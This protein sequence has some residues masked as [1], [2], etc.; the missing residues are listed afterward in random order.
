MKKIALLF[1]SLM[2]ISGCYGA[3][4]T[5]EEALQRV[6][7]SGE[8]PR[9]VKGA[10]NSMKLVMAGSG[11]TGDP[12]YYIFSS[13]GNTLFV[14]A[15]DIAVPL[16]GYTDS[17]NFDTN[18]MPP[19]LKW[20]LGEY[21]REIEWARE[22]AQ[23]KLSFEGERERKSGQRNKYGEAIAPL[24]S[25]TWSQT[26]P[27]N[28]YC[29][30]IN[31]AKTVTGC[32]ATAMAQTMKYHEWPQD[33]I[34]S[35]SYSWNGRRLTSRPLTPDWENM[36]DDYY[37][38]YTDEEAD[39]VARL[40]QVCGYSVEMMY[41][42]ASA[43]GSGAYSQN[44][45]NAMVERFGY[46]KSAIYLLRQFYHQ[47]EWAQMI[48][49]NLKEI[50]PVIY[51]GQGSLGGHS[52][53]CDGYDGNGMFHFNWGWSGMSDGY[54]ILSALDPDALGT[55]GGAGGFN[56]NQDIIL[57]IRRPQEDSVA[58]LPFIA[59]D[60]NMYMEVED[61]AVY[62]VPTDETYGGFF[63]YGNTTGEFAFGLQLK[64]VDTDLTYNIYY[65]EDGVEDNYIELPQYR[66]ITYYGV[67]LPEEIE[68]GR[69]KATPIYKLKENENAE[70]IRF[71]Y[72]FDGYTILVIDDESI[73][74][75]SPGEVLVESFNCE[76]GFE[77]GKE[78]DLT[79]TVS[80][81]YPEDKEDALDAYICT[82][83]NEYFQIV[84]QLGKASVLIPAQS[85]AELRYKGILPGL[86]GGIYYLVLARDY[87]VVDGF[88]IE[89]INLSGV[90]MNEISSEK[91]RYFN[92]Q[93]M[94]MK[95][96]NLEPG[97]YLVKT[98]N[99]I[100]KVLIK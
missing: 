68:A 4:L 46:D 90:Q 45:R 93:G 29:P 62:I 99:K 80:S 97:I 44:I 8:M 54:F 69:Y 92:L 49:D 28:K 34:K 65:S 16:L 18:E 85:T 1:A 61:G 58:P 26:E 47:D 60:C 31:G 100:M 2:T 88:E 67:D 87:E 25:T 91:S 71:P 39:A 84:A 56:Y 6:M 79:V 14:S 32:V 74:I 59:C 86:A 78:Y 5:S 10:D 7:T 36:L 43:G 95:G 9:A 15:D 35:I 27:Y 17:G 41:N 51:D 83:N 21:T 96:E 38:D 48:Y 66:G 50:G 89:V 52:F 72:Y 82:L 75:E 13:K 12:A 23:S 11:E 42:T 20:W 73:V 55:G 30:L 64:N 33:E 94:E 22:N 81:T 63:N 37:Y 98:G 76:T 57:K 70:Y 19:Q 24:L 3:L 77:A 53:V 40:M